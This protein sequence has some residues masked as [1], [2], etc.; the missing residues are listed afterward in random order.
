M[1]TADKLQKLLE[2]KAAIRN[3]IINKG[4]E[5]SDDTVF[6]DYASKIDAIEAGSSGGETYENPEFYEIRTGGGTSCRGLFAYYWG[7]SLDI[8][9]FDISNATRMDYMFTWCSNLKSL[10]VSNFDTSQVTTMY[11][12]F[13]YCQSLTSLDVSN[14]DTSQVKDMS[15]IFSNCNKLTS[16]DV[17]NFDTSQVTTMSSM[18]NYCYNLTS[19]DVS[20]FDTSNVTDMGNMFNGCSSLTSLDVSNFDTSKVTSVSYIFNGC[21]SLESLNL[22]SWDISKVTSLSSVFNNCTALTDLQAP[23]NISAALDVSKCSNL[24]HDSLMSIINNL[25][26]VSSSKKL[27]LGAT[28]LAKL[29]DE[30]KAIATSKNWTLA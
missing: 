18:F 1:A 10:D 17:S 20:N 26:T 5:V 9:N 3:A 27:T 16:L 7:A 30:E 15:N 11:N 25:A 24:T 21:T 29:T 6:A 23:K 8:S 22:S 28:N 13:Y 4:V 14:W 12:M 19:L 2:T